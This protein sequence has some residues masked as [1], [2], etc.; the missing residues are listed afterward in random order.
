MG[1]FS[2]SRTSVR[3]AS[4]I[5]GRPVSAGTKAGAGM[6]STLNG[7]RP[8]INIVTLNNVVTTT[9]QV[10]LKGC[11][12]KNDIDDVIGR[13]GI[14]QARLCKVTS[15]E[16]GQ[17]FKI[18]MS[19]TELPTASSNVGLDIDLRSSASLVRSYDFD[20][21]GGTSLIAAGG[22]WALG[23]TIEQLVTVPTANHGLYL[24]T[25]ATH[26]GDSVYTAGQLVITLYGH[27]LL[28]A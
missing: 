23:K 13:L 9:I 1:N 10:A 8:V 27:K 3:G 4:N 7:L 5:Q 28:T 15:A 25:G 24:T 21:S 2:S 19:C 18:S 20:L 22:D 16:M 12:N 11:S 26:T 14:A 6:V 17:I